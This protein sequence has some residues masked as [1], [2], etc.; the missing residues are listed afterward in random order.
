MRGRVWSGPRFD[1]PAVS[2]ANASVGE[3]VLAARARWGDGCS[4]NHKLFRQATQA[5]GAKALACWEACLESGDQ[6]AHFGMGYT[7]I[8]MDR[9]HEGYRHLRFYAELAPAHPWVQVWLAR[10]AIAI[11][12]TTEAIKALKRA[13][14]LEEAGG[15]E[16]DAAELLAEL[17]D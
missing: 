9:P 2:L 5:E 6:Q 13:V 15:V 17:V 8:D 14:K 7:L 16:T 3:I 1:A 12:E 4:F 11:V 10:G